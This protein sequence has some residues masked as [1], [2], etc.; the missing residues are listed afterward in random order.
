VQS[1]HPKEHSWRR[2]IPRIRW[3]SGDAP[4]L[5]SRLEIIQT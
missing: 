5:A 1:L 2:D 3:G 4:W